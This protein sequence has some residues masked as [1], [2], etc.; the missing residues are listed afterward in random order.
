MLAEHAMLGV[1]TGLQYFAVFRSVVVH[2]L[3]T[4]QP[5]LVLSHSPAYHHHCRRHHQG[6]PMFLG[7]WLAIDMSLGSIILLTW[8]HYS[9]AAA[10]VLAPAVA[11]G[12]I[13][14]S[15][16]WSIPASLLGVAGV[17]PPFCMGF[18]PFRM[19]GA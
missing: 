9:P 15:G 19:G 14:G 5:P 1:S 7:A 16:V 18:M 4:A 8:E 13:V 10:K 2:Q 11:S 3:P 17:Q 6:I 12:L